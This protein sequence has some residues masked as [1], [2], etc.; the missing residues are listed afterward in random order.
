MT[1]KKPLVGTARGF[2]QFE[3]D[4]EKF[5]KFGIMRRN[6]QKHVREA[7]EAMALHWHK[8]YLPMHFDEAAYQRYGYYKRKG[9]DK[10]GIRDRAIK[11]L[12]EAFR[13]TQGRSG[14]VTPEK[15][16]AEVQRVYNRTYTRR[17]ER[18]FGHNRP[19]NF[20][21]AG[22][23][24]ALSNPKIRSNS[25]Q[26]RVVL[27]SK[28]NFKSQYSR[29]SMRD[30]ITRLIPTEVADLLNVGRNALKHAIARPK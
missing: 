16:E 24:E 18:Q 29:I 8:T 17:K 5:K 6:L 11:N 23:L 7:L 22:M 9:M 27:P 25:K 3:V 12:N 4:P 13:R 2:L 19:L 30:E 21:G 20:T 26:A 1:K 14:E 10:A 15:I 28:F